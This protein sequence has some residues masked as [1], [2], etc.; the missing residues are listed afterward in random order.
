MFI[1]LKI[2]TVYFCFSI[3]SLKG[4]LGGIHQMA[5]SINEFMIPQ[6]EKLSDIQCQPESQLKF[7]LEA[8]TQVDYQPIVI[9][10]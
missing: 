10:F 5:I 8:W 7:I 1:F 2:I 4:F 3:L 9:S 6:L